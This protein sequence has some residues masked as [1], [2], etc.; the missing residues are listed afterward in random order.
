MP[1]ANGTNDTNGHSKTALYGDEEFVDHSYDYIIIGGGTA[2][3]C[4]TARLTEDPNVTVGVL[5]AGNIGWRTRNVLTP[6]LF[7]SLPAGNK[8]YLIPR[9]KL[10]GGSSGINYLMYVRGSKEDCNGWEALGNKGWGWED[11]QLM[12]HNAA[13]KH[14]RT[15]GL[16]HT[17]FTDY[18]MPMEEDFIKASYEV[19]KT[20]N[21]LVDAWSGDHLGIY[22][23]FGAIDRT[24]NVGTRSYAA[25]GYPKPNLSR[26][27]LKV[28]TQA[29]VSKIVLDTS[30]Q[31]E[32]RV[33]SHTT[34]EA[35]FIVSGQVH[36]ATANREIILSAG[37]IQTPQILELSGIG[38]S[39]ILSVVSIDAIVH[40]PSVGANFQDHEKLIVDQL[41]DPKF[42]N[43]Q[44]FLIPA[45]MDM[46]AGGDQTK[47][48]GPPPKGKQ[49]VTPLICLEH[50]L[51]R[52][53]VHITS[54]DPSKAPR[55][56]SG[57]LRNPTDSKILSAGLKWL[58]QVNRHPILAKSLGER[59]QLA[60]NVSLESEEERIEVIKEH[61]STQYHLIRTASIGEVVDDRLRV[62]GVKGLRVVDASVF[63]NH[64][65]GNIMSTT[66][67]VTEKGADLIKEDARHRCG[68]KL[69]VLPEGVYFVPFA[70]GQP[71]TV[72]AAAVVVGVLT[73]DVEDCV[74]VVVVEEVDPDEVEDNVDCAETDDEDEVETGS[75]A[76]EL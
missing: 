31:G 4:V 14:H 18:R 23:S 25:T 64:V 12:P 74:E 34:I 8:V 5:K 29:L 48:L 9:G 36:S 24:G 37:V 6:S 3:L 45:N 56:D 60:P 71:R 35:E 49:R 39:Q 28:L 40:N 47:F 32:P 20:K 53:T 66:Y 19:S 7:P 63:P 50:P 67:A 30:G 16:I 42:A 51:S 54:S 43:L 44:T 75:G 38:D 73:V 15:N 52:G 27:N 46:T 2:G 1:S 69:E 70:E 55:I 61:I 26:P 68:G 58:D 33:M 11:P 72:R 76:P 57:Y 13:E 62:Q 41:S 10:L 17:S 21:T 59:V 22:S 65:S